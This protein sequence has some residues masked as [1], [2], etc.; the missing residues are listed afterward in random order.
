MAEHL[1]RPILKGEYVIALDGDYSNVDLDN[2]KFFG[3]WKEMDWWQHRSN[4]TNLSSFRIGKKYEAHV[5]GILESYN[6]AVTDI[7]NNYWK[8]NLYSPFDLIVDSFSGKRY[9]IDVKYR[10]PNND[11]VIFPTARVAKQLTFESVGEKMIVICYR[12]KSTLSKV[13]LMEDILSKP[14]TTI[15]TTSFNVIKLSELQDLEEWIK[16]MV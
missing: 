4:I 2:L 16:I 13:V 15:R 12:K 1:R 14:T 10:T 9:L 8:E 7:S 5:Q 11:T 3:S 6:L